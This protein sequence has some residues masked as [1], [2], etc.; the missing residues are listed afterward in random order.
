MALKQQGTPDTQEPPWPHWLGLAFVPAETTSHSISITTMGQDKNKT[1][2]K[3]LLNT[4]KTWASSKPQKWE[5]IPASQLMSLVA[6]A[7]LT[8]VLASV[9]PCFWARFIKRPSIDYLCFLRASDTEQ[10]PVPFPS[11]QSP[12]I[13]RNLTVSFSGTFSEH[14][15]PPDCALPPAVSSRCCSHGYTVSLWPWRHP[16]LSFCTM[17]GNAPLLRILTYCEPVVSLLGIRC[18]ERGCAR[19]A[20]AR[21]CPLCRCFWC[22]CC[23][24]PGCP[25][26]QNA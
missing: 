13:S 11:P 10:S 26:A 5:S 2:L 20:Q 7:L 8:T 21:L 4:G 6:A 15:A 19:E 25:P 9:G 24:P 1:L 3:P 14:P 16:A 23:K 22:Q 17:T 12:H 18:R